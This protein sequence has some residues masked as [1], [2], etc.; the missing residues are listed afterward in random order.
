VRDSATTTKLRVGDQVRVI[1]GREKGKEGRILGIN[2]VKGRVVVEGLNTVKKAVRPTQQNQ[3]GG[4][5]DV[6]AAL[7]LSN[8][9]IVC[10]RCGISRIGFSL[11]REQKTRVCRKCGEEL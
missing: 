6:E 11:E 5:T 7:N 8:V 3:K 2:T 4:I 10:K 9:M 1:A